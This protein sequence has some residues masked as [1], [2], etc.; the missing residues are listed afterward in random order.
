MEVTRDH[1]PAPRPDPVA[2]A[3]ARHA[4][5]DAAVREWGANG[6]R[7][8]SE[9]ETARRE[10]AGLGIRIDS[11]LPREVEAALHARRD[12]PRWER[13]IEPQS[14]KAVGE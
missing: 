14:L 10:L 7:V 12:V 8:L 4:R 3:L 2:L 13:P 5:A 1:E 9:Y 6:K 11:K